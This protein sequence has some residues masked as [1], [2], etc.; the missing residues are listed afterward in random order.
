MTK[1]C[2]SVFRLLFP[3]M[4]HLTLLG[5]EGNVNIRFATCDGPRHSDPHMLRC[6]AGRAWLD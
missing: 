4:F 1:V 3:L 5:K 6:L 2:L